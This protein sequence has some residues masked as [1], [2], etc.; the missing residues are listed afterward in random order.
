MS[1]KPNIIAETGLQFYGRMSAS[2]SHEIKNV[3]GI[4]NENAGLLEDFTL[5]ADRGIPIDPAR[6]KKMAATVMNHVSRG[7]EI[8]KSMNRLA[9]SI[10][11]TIAA[12]E[13]NKIIELFIALTARLTA[14]RTVTVEP[15]LS[16]NPVTIR[17]S[18]FFL[19]NLLWLCLEFA[20]DAGGEIK[21]VELATEQTE[22]GAKIK[23]RQLAG[24]PDAVLKS[25]PSE[26]E[27]SLLDLLEADLTVDPV[28]GEIV[29]KLS[30]SFTK[31]GGGVH[32]QKKGE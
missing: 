12:V 14:M 32:G 11:S 9:H 6:L 2:I 28:A 20:M 24:L 13:V 16:E 29:L 15:N 3:L 10:D 17:T 30:D 25:F 7:D 31:P 19:I 26:R 23:F 22:N 27:K 1:I 5:M 21:Q 18:P 8:I 4:I